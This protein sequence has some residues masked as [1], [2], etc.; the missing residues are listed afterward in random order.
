MQV[1]TI[2]SRAERISAL[3]GPNQFLSHVLL[4]A[5]SNRSVEVWDAA[6]GSLI[7]ELRETHERVPHAL[8]LNEASSFVSHPSESYDLFLSAAAD[9]V[10]AMWDLRYTRVPGSFHTRMHTHTHTHTHTGEAGAVF[11]HG[12]LHLSSCWRQG[13]AV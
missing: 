11:L 2:Q 12:P 8:V 3:A 13:A 9:G 10:V 7:H 5:C 1:A 4:T 6:T